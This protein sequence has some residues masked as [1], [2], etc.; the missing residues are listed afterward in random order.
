MLCIEFTRGVYVVI[1]QGT[2]AE[3]WKEVRPTC[4]LAVPRVWEK[5]QEK[6]IATG[7]QAPKMKKKIIAWAKDKGLR[8][9]QAQMKG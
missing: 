1:F 7:S 5:I 2:L 8:G 6:M 9:I 4:V 3:T